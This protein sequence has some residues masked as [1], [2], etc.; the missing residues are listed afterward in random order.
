MDYIDLRANPLNAKAYEAH[1]PQIRQQTPWTQLY[2]DPIPEP[3]TLALLAIVAAALMAR[4]RR[5]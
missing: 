1:I 5:G 2:Y 3:S 4:R